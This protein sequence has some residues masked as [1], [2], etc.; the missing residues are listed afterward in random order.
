LLLLVPPLEAKEPARRF[1]DALRQHGYFEQALDYL[2][3]VRDSGEGEAGFREVIDYEAAL[4]LI[5]W[6]HAGRSAAEGEKL[7]DRADQR[8]ARFL[9][10]H[11][12]HVLAAAAKT[13]LAGVLV[14]RG[15]LKA[16]QARSFDPRARQQSIESVRG[17]YR[18]AETAFSASEK[19]F[20]DVLAKLPRFIDPKDTPRLEQREQVR[21]DLLQTRLALAG[22]HAEIAQT[23]PPGTAER[24]TN[25]CEAAKEYGELYDK[26]R[27][28]LGGLYAR[29]G[30]ARCWKELGQPD[31]ALVMLIELL[32]ERGESEALAAVKTQATRL[33]METALAPGV[34]KYRE[35]LEFYEAWRAAARGSEPAGAETAAIQCFAGQAALDY[36]RSLGAGKE[37]VA[38]RAECLATARQTLAAAADRSGPFQSKAMALLSDP[39]LRRPGVTL[40]EPAGFAQARDRAAAALDRMAQAESESAESDAAGRAEG[41]GPRAAEIAAARQ[42][43]IQYYTLALKSPAAEVPVDERDAVRSCLA[44]LHYKAGDWP[45]AAALAEELAR[46]DPSP[47]Q[48]RRAA[49]I[50]LAARTALLNQAAAGPQRRAAAGRMTAAAEFIVQHW[51]DEPEAALIAGQAAW[52]AWVAAWRGSASRR[53]PAAELDLLLDRARQ[54]LTAAVQPARHAAGPEGKV[55]PSPA[56]LAAVLALAEIELSAGHADEAVAWLEDP[57]IGPRKWADRRGAAIPLELAEETYRVSLRAYVAAKQWA[58]AEAALR[59]LEPVDP[60]SPAAARG[61]TQAMIRSGRDLQEHLQ[62]LRGQTR[63][64][65]LADFQSSLERFL[66]Q[67]ANRPQGNS[68]F[69]LQWVAEAYIGLGAALDAPAADAE[70]PEPLPPRAAE[71][72]RAA[73][74]TYSRLL[75]QCETDE[76]FCASAEALAALKIRLAACLR[77]LGEYR[78]AIALLAVVLKDDPRL[79]DAQAEAAYTYQQWGAEKPGYYLLAI[80]GSRKYRDIWGWGELARR[81]AADGTLRETFCAARYNLALC[82]FQLARHAATA[83][84]RAE[85]LARAEDDLRAGGDASWPRDDPSWYDKSEALLQTI[86]KARG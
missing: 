50:A 46:Q 34:E 61:A 69:S 44:Y 84:E 48:A 45:E 30:E 58:P 17:L 47:P 78:Q 53:P 12:R 13:Q 75:H 70:A 20:E 76:G 43:A 62:R 55:P 9:V 5:D 18:Q 51:P 39:L 41:G 80:T 42:E 26:H 54:L 11:P 56:V 64:G 21:R 24:Q 4:T 81:S 52:S 73:A 57:K 32:A 37:Q 35:A 68:F 77:H 3:E 10:E 74:D 40:A 85:L 38:L 49:R 27:R 72:Y 65:A 60:Q 31:R 67:V 59:G 1:Y 83:A 16:E 19:Q 23:Y 36:A 14:E 28:D 63:S 29:L 22:V 15:R 33:A 2:D 25:L 86:R 71:H 66:W 6:A 82:R 8:L 79:V 7:L